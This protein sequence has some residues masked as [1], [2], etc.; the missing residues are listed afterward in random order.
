MANRQFLHIAGW[1]WAFLLNAAMSIAVGGVAWVAGEDSRPRGFHFASVGKIQIRSFLKQAI[2]DLLVVWKIPSFK[3][4]IFQGCFGSIPWAAMFYW[5]LWL[6]L[7]CFSHPSAATIS[8]LLQVGVMI[9]ASIGGGILADYAHRVSP[10]HGRPLIA[11]VAVLV[12]VPFVVFILYRLPDSSS[13]NAVM[14]YAVMFL[15]FG[16]SISWAGNTNATIFS[17]IVPQEIR[18]SVYALDQAFE[19]GIGSAGALVVG[20]VAAAYGF[21]EHPQSSSGMGMQPQSACNRHDAAK[22]SRA[23]M[24]TMGPPWFIAFC[25]YV[26][27]HFTYRHDRIVEESTKHDGEPNLNETCRLVG[28]IT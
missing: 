28:G 16:L 20:A 25:G 18:S 2:A 5:T 24:L 4:I 13:P 23:L 8:S 9:G 19:G 22:L 27:L 1:R 12:G 17:E 26:L 10:N 3:V 14:I 21:G 15:C 11:Q 7:K 6:E